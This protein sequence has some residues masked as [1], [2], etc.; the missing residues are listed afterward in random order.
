MRALL[1][2]VLR[3]IASAIELDMTPTDSDLTDKKK[4]RME[5]S[6]SSNSSNASKARSKTDDVETNIDKPTAR[7]DIKP[8]RRNPSYTHSNWDS[9]QHR[10]DY[11]QGYRAEGKD[12]D[13]G[14]NYVKKNKKK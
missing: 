9:K 3:K 1:S 10:K 5:V 12:V 4:K 14:N 8:P 6:E 7:P 2:D 13:N 11:M